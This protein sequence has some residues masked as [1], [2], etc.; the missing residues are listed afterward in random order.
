MKMIIKL[1]INFFSVVT[2]IITLVAFYLQI[3]GGSL[4]NFTDQVQTW[5]LQTEI[6]KIEA[7][8]RL[9][10]ANIE[11]REAEIRLKKQEVKLFELQK[12]AEADRRRDIANAEARKRRDLAEAEAKKRRDFEKAKEDEARRLKEIA[13]AKETEKTKG[14]IR[15]V[16]EGIIVVGLKMLLK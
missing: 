12:K 2:V 6:Q 4:K 14:F 13:D 10:Q 9:K 11:K 15:K 7:E 1:I 3:S 16:G 8:T 5:Q